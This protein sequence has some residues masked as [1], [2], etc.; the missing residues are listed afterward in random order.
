MSNHRADSV[1]LRGEAGE[2]VQ[3]NSHKQR[4]CLQGLKVSTLDHVQRS[5]HCWHCE[6]N[7]VT[8]V[9]NTL[10]KSKSLCR[11][12]WLHLTMLHLRVRQDLECLQ[13]KL[14]AR[15]RQMKVTWRIE[16]QPLHAT[17]EHF[18]Q[19]SAQRTVAQPSHVWP[20]VSP[21]GRIFSL[22][23]MDL[24]VSRT[25]NAQ[26]CSNAKQVGLHVLPLQLK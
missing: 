15:F 12:W 9:W 11:W 25:S 10:G 20:S 3:E 24:I 5:L 7:S 22:P 19:R 21:S 18:V 17:Y 23:Q 16:Q 8:Q 2:L 13:I 26:G 4:G 6:A 14:K 1:W